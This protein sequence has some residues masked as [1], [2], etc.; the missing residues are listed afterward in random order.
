M[1]RRTSRQISRK[2]H[3]PVTPRARPIHQDTERI[4]TN[5]IAADVDP[6]MSH[7]WF[8]MADMEDHPMTDETPTQ[9]TLL[10]PPSVPVQFRL[11]RATRERGLRH[12]AEIRQLLAE[13]RAAATR[14]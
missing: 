10:P 2:A 6:S 12:I 13:R 1:P 14:P 3:E 8:T 7:P 5:P 4:L 11:D 9:L